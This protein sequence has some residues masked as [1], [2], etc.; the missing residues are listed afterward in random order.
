MAVSN[1]PAVDLDQGML[2]VRLTGSSTNKHT[3]EA[4]LSSSQPQA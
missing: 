4:T 2:R 1:E 3:Q